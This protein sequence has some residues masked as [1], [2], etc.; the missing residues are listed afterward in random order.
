MTSRPL[1]FGKFGGV[2]RRPRLDSGLAASRIIC[3]KL[4]YRFGVCWKDGCE[5][6]GVGGMLVIAMLLPVDRDGAGRFP[7]SK[8]EPMRLSTQRRP[9]FT[10]VELLVVIAIIGI[11]VG[12]L[13][14]SLQ[15]AREAARRVTC[16]SHLK[17]LA[18]AIKHYNTSNN[19]YPPSGI[20]ETLTDREKEL[21]G[22]YYNRVKFES[23]SHPLYCEE[24]VVR[25]RLDAP[26]DPP[27]DPRR[28]KMIGWGV[29]I[30]PFLGQDPLYQ[31]FDLSRNILDQPNEPQEMHVE[32]MMCPSDRARNR[33]FSHPSLTQ[34]KRLAK[35]N[36]AAYVSPL[37]V[38]W[39]GLLPGALTTHRVQTTASVRDGESKTIMLSEVRT[40]PHEYDQRG[41]WSLPW[42]GSSVLALDF[43][44]DCRKKPNYVPYPPVAKY[45]QMPNFDGT[46]DAAQGMLTNGDMLYACPDPAGDQL[47]GMIC[48]EY[49][50]GSQ[51]SW[52]SAAARSYHP[53]GVQVVFMD[54]HTGYVQNSIDLVALALLISSDDGQRV[55]VGEHVK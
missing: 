28:G 27:V 14:P 21:I 24:Q 47:E 36:Y 35:G 8:H 13:L 55:S 54:G 40:R 25:P 41:V 18:D 53:G 49:S 5:T 7:W 26:L 51:W 23:V 30:L 12:L 48:H 39:Q 37:H 43:H 22:A 52:L 45:S 44:R 1:N 16:M 17:Q 2:G 15:S 29:I 19:M 31:Q 46:D 9:G 10:L 42:N 11:L 33:Y 50:H 38:E 32:E 20:Y 34:G 6:P 3:G 4:P